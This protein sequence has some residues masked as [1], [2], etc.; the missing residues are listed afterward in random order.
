[1]DIPV[2]G[3][4]FSIEAV[5]TWFRDRRGRDP[6]EME[7]NMILAEMAAREATFPREGPNVDPRGWRSDPAAPSAT[8]R[9]G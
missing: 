2:E 6:S 5:T 7:L 9:R 4:P 3:Y 1:M 8:R